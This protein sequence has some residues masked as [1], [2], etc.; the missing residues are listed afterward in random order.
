MNKRDGPHVADRRSERA[1]GE[2]VGEPG[3]LLHP[4]ETRR[5]V[6]L[7]RHPVDPRLEAFVDYFWVVRWRVAAPFETAVLT[8]PKVHVVVEQGRMLAYGVSRRTFTRRLEGVGA[9]IGAAFRPA[10]F[11][12]FLP[13]DA[14]AADIADRVVPLDLIW[15]VDDR[16][17][18]AGVRRGDDETVWAARFADVLASR[19]PVLSDDAV[20]V[21][22]LVRMIEDDRTLR[23]VDELAAASGRGVRALQRLF[24]DQ[25]GASPKWV[26]RQ[27]RLLD[28]AEAIHAGSEVGW[29]ELA[30][31]L[32]YADQSHLV[33]DFSA[34]VGSP[35]AAYARA[36]EMAVEMAVEG[37]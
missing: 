35:P 31:A 21:D 36:V 13:Q 2:P 16:A 17:L 19:G 4:D 33:R 14:S 15:G 7:S 12:A 22:R 25:L 37:S 24:R 34:A 1:A 3:A 28:A 29:T 9:A 10:G 32:G 30:V 8:Q 20:E 27:R 6:D 11:R 23:R 18:A 5:Q 26:I